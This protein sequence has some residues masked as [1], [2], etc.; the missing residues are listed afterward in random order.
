M[1]NNLRSRSAET[2]MKYIV[3]AG[4]RINR[5]IADL[6]AKHFSGGA[7]E[8]LGVDACDSAFITDRTSAVRQTLLSFDPFQQFAYEYESLNQIFNQTFVQLTPRNLK[9]CNEIDNAAIMY[10]MG[11]TNPHVTRMGMPV[12]VSN[13]CAKLTVREPGSNKRVP[14]TTKVCSSGLD[15]VKWVNDMRRMMYR[16]FVGVFDDSDRQKITTWRRT[17]VRSLYDYCTFVESK[18]T[19]AP[20]DVGFDVAM[21]EGP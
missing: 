5:N 1:N 12:V 6:R 19:Y 18:L 20:E 21:N 17:T 16:S 4:S 15:Y 7:G 3:V 10:R 9:T 14:D 8:M 11:Q 2:G 13:A